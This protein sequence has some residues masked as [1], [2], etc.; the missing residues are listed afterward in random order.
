MDFPAT[1]SEAGEVA[2]YHN[3]LGVRHGTYYRY[4]SNGTKALQAV[5]RL[6][7]LVESKQWDAAGKPVE[8]T[9]GAQTGSR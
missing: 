4:H 8:S 5:W 9:D 2:R 3:S 1:T 7:E 6:G